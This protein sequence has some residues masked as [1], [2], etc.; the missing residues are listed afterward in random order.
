MAPQN[1]NMGLLLT[2]EF[3][4]KDTSISYLQGNNKILSQEYVEK[5]P[6]YNKSHL[7]KQGRK[8][9][10]ALLKP[11]TID[12]LQMM[13][14]FLTPGTSAAS[15]NEETLSSSFL[16]LDGFQTIF[17]GALKT[18]D[19]KSTC[20]M[21]DDSVERWGARLETNICVGK[22]CYEYRHDNEEQEEKCLSFSSSD[23][24]DD[25]APSGSIL[26]QKLDLVPLVLD[27]PLTND[28][29]VINPERYVP[30]SHKMVADCLK[31]SK[32]T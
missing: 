18:D 13:Q 27:D 6:M 9:R 28:V 7:S 4:T 32:H 14:A 10:F 25:A 26:S 12:P 21:L 5:D 2:S 15:C 8:K 17:L 31:V 22:V 16:I 29:G 19:D 20:N 24:E 11:M 3:S 30:P 1:L 23:G